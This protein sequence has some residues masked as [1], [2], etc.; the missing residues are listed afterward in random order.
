MNCFR[1]GN[2]SFPL[3]RKTYVMGILNV[4]PDSFSDA[5]KYLDVNAAVAHALEM[6]EQ[7]ADIIDIGP[8]STRPGAHHVSSEIEIER[9]AYVLEALKGRLNVPVSVDTFYPET[10]EYALNNGASI[11]NDVSGSVEGSMATVVNSHKA[12]WIIMHNCGGAAS[13][14]EYCGGVINAVR[15][16]FEDSLKRAGELCV[17][18]DRICHDV[19]IGFGK[20]HEDNLLLIRELRKTKIEGIALLVGASR[21]RLIGIAAN[22]P[23]PKARDAGTVAVHTLA[24]AGGADI[25]RVHNVRQAVQAARTVEAILYG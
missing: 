20:R 15:D 9:L 23:E 1:A 19:G 10:A 25:I 8:Q 3:G 18:R 2:N 12:G 7:G 16:F 14:P 17:D 21:K 24:I 6:Q 11:V 13:Q 4:T 22:E 5:G